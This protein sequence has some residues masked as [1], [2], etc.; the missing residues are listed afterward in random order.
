M[1]AY[2]LD[3]NVV[4]SCEDRDHRN[5]LIGRNLSA[6]TTR[7]F[8]VDSNSD[9]AAFEVERCQLADIDLN[10]I[11]AFDRETMPAERAKVREPIGTDCQRE[12]LSVR[13]VPIER[14]GGRRSSN[15][16][17]RSSGRG[18]VFTLGGVR[19]VD[20]RDG[21]P[22][23]RNRRPRVEQRGAVQVV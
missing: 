8:Q 17:A 2:D 16:A 5:Y 6:D 22:L 3:A 13:Q 21:A 1:A 12:G 20:G 7:R 19:R 9:F 11:G 23:H 4:N 18:V 14:A 15:E 10:H